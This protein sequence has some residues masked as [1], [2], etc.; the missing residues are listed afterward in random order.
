MAIVSMTD[1]T[2]N[3]IAS[4]AEYNKLIDNIQDL[5]ARLGAVT[6]ASTAHARLAALETLTGGA[7]NGNAAL[8]AKVQ[9]GTIGNT[10]L[11]ALVNSG[12]VG[13]SALDARVTVLE[14]SSAVDNAG[15]IIARGAR[16]TSSASSNSSTLV[17]VLRVSSI[18]LIS[19]RLYRIRWA[20]TLNDTNTAYN[21]AP[22]AD[23][24]IQLHFTTNA[25]NATT[26]SSVLPG[27]VAFAPELRNPIANDTFYVPGANQTV[28]LLLAFA[29]NNG[30]TG[31]SLFADSDRQTVISVVDCGVDPGN[32]GTSL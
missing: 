10:A 21:Q 12:T 18:S 4:S 23:A 29:R 32:T 25:T 9:S 11:G 15:R 3:G 22:Q 26:A 31:V 24:Q 28:S 20:T 13:N 27:S 30:S 6:A 14:G 5:D 7:T 8:G 19:G 17:A 1:A 2:L 16:T